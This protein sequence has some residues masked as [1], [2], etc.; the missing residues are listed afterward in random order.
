MSPAPLSV[1][2]RFCNLVILATGAR[3]STVTLDFA[4][5]ALLARAVDLAGRSRGGGCRGG[6][7][8]AA[9]ERVEHAVTPVTGPVFAAVVMELEPV[10]AL[11]LVLVV[12]VGNCTALG[13]E[14]DP[15]E[16]ETF[17]GKLRCGS[18]GGNLRGEG[19]EGEIVD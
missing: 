17:G 3:V 7:T 10:L 19:L 8:P 1:L 13:T 6:E 9:V 5:C 15:I 4:P 2:T 16:R 12:V 14:R 11:V 18:G